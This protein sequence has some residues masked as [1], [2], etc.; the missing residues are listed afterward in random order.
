MYADWKS[1]SSD[2]VFI[3]L[4]HENSLVTALMHHYLLLNSL[5]DL[6][7]L[8]NR[9]KDFLHII[10][11]LSIIS[12]NSK[13]KN[14]TLCALCRR[15]LLCYIV[16][17]LFRIIIIYQKFW[18]DIYYRKYFSMFFLAKNF[19]GIFYVYLNIGLLINKCQ[20]I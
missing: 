1:I 9:R 14:A 17:L 7:F 19:S 13:T 4:C 8:F 11:S 2:S 18:N 5:S 10:F 12:K 20:L 16:M 15:K 3:S 6:H